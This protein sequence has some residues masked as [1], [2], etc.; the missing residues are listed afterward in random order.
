M[1]NIE[2]KHGVCLGTE[3][4]CIKQGTIKAMVVAAQIYNM[5]GATLTVTSVFDGK[6]KKGSKHY[7]GLAFDCR[8]YNLTDKQ[9][10]DIYRNLKLGLSGCGYDIVVEKDHIHIEYDPK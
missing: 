7:E 10:Q 6:H 8:T 3:L 4:S 9:L 5:F 1:I 2:F